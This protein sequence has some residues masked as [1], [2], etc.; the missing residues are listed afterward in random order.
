ME[1]TG[2]KIFPAILNFA[3]S[4]LGMTKVLISVGLV[5]ALLVAIQ[6]LFPV[7]KAV[8]RDIEYG[9]CLLVDSPYSATTG[10]ISKIQRALGFSNQDNEDHSQHNDRWRDESPGWANPHPQDHPFPGALPIA[11]QV[12]KKLT[13]N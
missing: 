11:Q 12:W 8:Q 6:I 13:E 4:I 3:S 10:Q 1:L 2:A 5:L 9:R 7:A